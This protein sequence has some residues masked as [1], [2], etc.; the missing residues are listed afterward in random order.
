MKKFWEFTLQALW[1]HVV[2]K[3]IKWL[4]TWAK[5]KKM[6]AEVDQETLAIKEVRKKIDDFFK[7]NPD[8]EEIPPNLELE[9]RRATRPR[10]DKLH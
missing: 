4:V 9:L 6:E 2:P 7:A 3:V 5:R 8:A 10:A 1:D